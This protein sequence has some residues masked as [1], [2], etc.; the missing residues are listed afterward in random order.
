MNNLKWLSNACGWL[1]TVTSGVVVASASFYTEIIGDNPKSEWIMIVAWCAL[2]VS[3]VSGVLCYFST[4]KQFIN[5]KYEIAEWSRW[6][7]VTYSIMLFSF[8][9]GMLFFGIYIL[10]NKL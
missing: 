2:I 3:I 6:I 7:N 5:K 10:Y 4:F 1:V 9:G 8:L